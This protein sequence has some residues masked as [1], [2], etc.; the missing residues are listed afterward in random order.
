MCTHSFQHIALPLLHFIQ[1]MNGNEINTFLNQPLLNMICWVNTWSEQDVMSDMILWRLNLI[2]GLRWIGTN[3]EIHK[4]IHS[5]L[6][7]LNGVISCTFRLKQFDTES[8]HADITQT[9]LRNWGRK[10]NRAYLQ[11][12]LVWVEE[13]ERGEES[14]C[15]NRDS[16][17]GM[18]YTNSQTRESSESKTV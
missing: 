15:R 10:R 13:E 5:N 1:L 17:L 16:W 11:S 2:K 6:H 14:R 8:N 18:L 12:S 4:T 3:C 9:R 7:L